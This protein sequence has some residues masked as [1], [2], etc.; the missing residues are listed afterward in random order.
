MPH[1]CHSQKTLS[2]LGLPPAVEAELNAK[3]PS[4]DPDW[5]VMPEVNWGTYDGAMYYRGGALLYLN[6]QLPTNDVQEDDL[7]KFSDIDQ[8][9]G[10]YKMISVRNE[11]KNGQWIQS[12]QA[13]RDLTIPS[14]FIPRSSVGS[15]GWE[16]FVASVV[17]EAGGVA[18]SGGFGGNSGTAIQS[19]AVRETETRQAAAE[20][21]TSVVNT[22]HVP[23]GRVSSARLPG[24]MGAIPVGSETNALDVISENNRILGLSKVRPPATPRSTNNNVQ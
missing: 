13:F 20:A 21:R 1:L 23:V 16:A 17:A 12:V 22:Q 3:M 4:I 15:E 18:T 10:I 8:V 11:F 19:P 6:S 5:G 14:Q 9:I 7:M 2:K 24:V